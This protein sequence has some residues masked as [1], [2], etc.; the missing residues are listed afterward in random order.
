MIMAKKRAN[1]EG[2]IAVTDSSLL[3]I[4]DRVFKILELYDFDAHEMSS[5][6]R[7]ESIDGVRFLYSDTSDGIFVAWRSN[8]EDAYRAVNLADAYASG[9]ITKEEL[10]W[11]ARIWSCRD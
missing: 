7:P 11:I 5:E 3:F 8:G 10:T 1:G 6:Y 4:G 9:D 2:N